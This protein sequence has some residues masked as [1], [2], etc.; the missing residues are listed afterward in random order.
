M[1]PRPSTQ[2]LPTPAVQTLGALVTG[3]SQVTFRGWAP[4]A[5]TLAVE[6]LGSQSEIIPMQP[7]P[8]GYWETTVTNIGVGTRYQYVLHEKLT[9]PDPASRY[10]PDGVHG[11]SEVF[12]PSSFVWTDQ[13]WKGLPV[14]DY[15]IYELHPGTFTKEG[16][17]D[18]IIP[19]L[20][21]L[22]DDVGITALELMPIAQFP[23]ARNWG[24]DGT[25]LFAPQNTY[26][27]P[28]ALQRLIDACHGAGLA[29]VLDVVYNHL[30]PEGNY[31]GDFG[32]LFTDH[33]RTPWGSAMNYDGPHSD[34][35]RN[36]IISNA[37][38]WTRDFHID[39][40]RL[41]AVHGIFDSSPT[42]ILKDIRDAVHGAAKQDSRSVAVIAES[43]FNDSKLLSSPSKG[44]YGLD[45]QWNDDFHHALHAL[46]TNERQGYY[47]DFG[48]LD[49][50]AT[51]LRKHFVL[52]GQYSHHRHRKHGNSAAHLLPSQFVVF[53]QNHD[54]IGNRAQGDRLSTLI[55]LAAQQVVTASV[56]LSPFIPLLFMG[57]EY[58]E[59]A[60]FQYFIDHGDK[61]LIEAVRKGRLAEF[62]PFGWKNIP[63]PYASTTFDRSRLTPPETR[64]DS[65][66]G[67]AA[68]TKQLIA[69]RKQ[70]ASLGAGVKGHQL[71]VWLNSEKTILTIYRKNPNA[72]AML[73]IFGFNDQPA[74]LSLRQPKS[75]WDLLLDNTQLEYSDP[76]NR[77]LPN[78]PTDLDLRVGKQTVTLPA[79]PA[80]IYKQA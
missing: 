77:T 43:D 17:F 70:H 68:W 22:R 76:N 12:D 51:A 26:G 8:F 9:R 74:T 4:W 47:S 67:L 31:W 23:G 35:V 75:Q 53:A 21:H 64:N 80:R 10:Q 16:T 41:D 62:K 38:Y 24:Y 71:R 61:G 44:G 3:P 79:F 29:V 65:Q 19:H 36:L 58:G 14:Q 73:L 49:H 57:E 15:I 18:A 7:Q 33:Y 60:P 69:L 54:Q 25:Y 34:A 2:K 13:Q 78:A 48:T 30:G 56:L 11:P 63:D 40:L 37:I 20:Q 39:A 45:A 28:Q 5:K 55:P 42:H 72:D 32:P 1:S 27:G 52:S 50:V 6:I 46:V 59:R 66:Q